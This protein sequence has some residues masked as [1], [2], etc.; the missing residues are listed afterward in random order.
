MNIANEIVLDTTHHKLLEKYEI[1]NET[2]EKEKPKRLHP[3]EW[4]KMLEQN[5]EES[6]A[7]SLKL[8]RD[9][10]AKEGEV[11]SLYELLR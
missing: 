1:V 11:M 2:L 10:E 5:V 6:R 8:A 9:L 7:T 3:Q 4:V